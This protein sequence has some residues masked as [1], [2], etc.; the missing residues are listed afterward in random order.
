MPSWPRAN[1]TWPCSLHYIGMGARSFIRHAD[2]SIS[3][4]HFNELAAIRPRFPKAD[5]VCIYDASLSQGNTVLVVFLARADLYL[6]EKYLRR[7]RKEITI[8]A[9]VFALFWI[10]L[11][12]RL[13]DR[14]A[15]FLRITLLAYD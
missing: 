13:T 4:S 3:F 7:K 2:L 5:A 15:I 9:A 11:E 12:T 1:R 10:D 8:F 14:A 6:P